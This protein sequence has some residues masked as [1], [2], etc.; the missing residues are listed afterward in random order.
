MAHVPPALPVRAVLL[1]S[2]R[3]VVNSARW[4]ALS[5]GYRDSIGVRA[6]YREDR[7]RKHSC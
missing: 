4:D 5:L 3:H 6:L 1:L 7:S 2:I